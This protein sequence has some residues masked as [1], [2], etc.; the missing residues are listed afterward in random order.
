MALKIIIAS[1]SFKGSLSSLEVGEAA[2]KGI[3]NVVPDADVTILP[4]AD[5]GEGTAELLS[6]SLGGRKI[7]IKVSDPIGRPISASYFI[8]D[9]IAIIEMAAASG[10]PLLSPEERNPTVTTSYGTGQLILDALRR[11]IRRF[12]I[13]LGGSATNDAGVGMLKALGFRF[14]DSGGL[15]VGLGGLET[16]RIRSIDSYHALPELKEATFT[17]ACDVTNPLTGTNGASQIYGPQKGATDE[18][19]ELLDSA[20]SS[21]GEIIRKRTGIDY[22][23][24]P[25]A[26]AAGGMGFAFLSFLNSTLRPGVEIVLDVLD[27]DKRIEGADL[28]ITGEGRLDRQTCMGKAPSGVLKRCMARKIPVVA[29]G[30]AIDRDAIPDLMNAGFKAAI[31]IVSTPIPLEEAM[32]PEVAKRNIEKTIETLENKGA[33]FLTKTGSFGGR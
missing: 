5:G 33:C 8:A 26:G 17:I 31:P 19:V 25:G 3:L 14:L 6:R 9:D 12:Y 11:G 22:S 4:L 20:L 7:E 27:F 32:R 13:G 23:S 1:D 28:V 15:P 21:F 18:M 30:G 10:L 2:K 24:V 29:I 16:G